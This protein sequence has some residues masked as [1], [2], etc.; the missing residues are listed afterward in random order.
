MRTRISVAVVA[1]AGKTF[2]GGLKELRKV[3]A[4]A[5]HPEPIWYEVPK[6]SKARKAV[7]RAVKNGARLLFVW[8]GDGMVQRC[9]D[10]LAGS[11]VA[12]AIIPA[13]TANLLATN[14]G[15]PRNIARAV[16]IGLRG[17]R[18]Q[19]DVG[20][21]N[22]ERFAVM[23]GTGFDAIMM[24]DVD[25]AKKQRL[26]RL[27][28]FRSGAKAMQAR[29]VRMRIRVDG[30]E[31]FAGKASCVLV[32]NVGTVTGGLEVFANASSSDGKLDIGVVTASSTWQWVRVFSRVVRGH[33]DRSPLINTTRGKKIVIE[34]ARKRPYELDGGA[35][36]PVKRLKIRV[37]AG[38]LAVCAPASRDTA[39][40][41]RRR[42]PRARPAAP[43]PS[44]AAAAPPPPQAAAP[45]APSA[46]D[47]DVAAMSV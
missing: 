34:L 7:R 8:G 29:S 20:V 2:G 25:G 38:A 37:K 12:L 17:P 3:L 27:A 31:W 44:Q 39:R 46:N 4:A 42:A 35:R 24:R 1:H 13:G 45:P 28:Y 19:V 5:G 23:A 40:P 14:F 21:V 30:D 16:D 15:I 6:S 18:R 36:P 22:G 9:I 11:D 26:G 43:P 32:G 47:V 33:L 41:P 10:A